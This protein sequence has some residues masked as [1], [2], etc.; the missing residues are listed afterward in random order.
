M[1]RALWGRESF[2]ATLFGSTWLRLVFEL[3]FLGVPLLVHAGV[4]LAL[5]A[6]PRRDER[7]YPEARRTSHVLQRVTG[8]I[9]LGFVA[10]HLWHTRGRVLTREIGSSDLYGELAAAL[11]ATS[12]LGVPWWA[13]LYLAGLAASVHHFSNGLIGFSASF[14]LVR[15][16]HALQ[17]LT[18]VCAVSGVILFVVGAATLLH[19][20]TGSPSFGGSS[21]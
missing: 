7:R 21:P 1:L 10:V 2:E 13:L 16:E 4:G 3:V 12:W 14:E 19:F 8:V 5:V 11:S 6:R 15:T 18:R 20:A 17:R 9:T